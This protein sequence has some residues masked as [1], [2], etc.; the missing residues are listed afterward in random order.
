MNSETITLPHG[1]TATVCNDESPENPFADYL[2][3]VPLAVFGLRDRLHAP[4]KDA[5]TVSL[6][7]LF[8]MLPE[9]E[10]G[11]P[12]RR[13]AII[14]AVGIET[15]WESHFD[16]EPDAEAWRWAIR[17]ELPES[18]GYWGE[19]ETYF[20]SMEALCG[21]LAIPCHQTVSNGYS[22]GDCVRLFA[23]ALPAWRGEVGAPDDCA[24]QCKG[25]CELY[26][27][28]AWGDVYGVSEI[29][30]PDGEEVEDGACW[31]F[32]GSDHEASGL[33]EH[34]REQ[35]L[36]DLENRAK[37]AAERERIACQYILVPV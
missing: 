21:L 29:F 11:K 2:S 35:I 33:L 15:G 26:G 30:R 22:Q 34:C 31:G 9:E 36:W 37:E 10:F 32:Y 14:K 16:G 4:A 25:A 7:D 13:A 20:D 12:E 17:E 24:D 19:A 23:A 27:Q 6:A 18:P 28:W 3:E 1:Y 5:A 8:D